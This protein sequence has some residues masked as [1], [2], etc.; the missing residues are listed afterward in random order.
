M[1]KMK[2]FGKLILDSISTFDNLSSTMGEKIFNT[3]ISIKQNNRYSIRDEYLNTSVKKN[4]DMN[5]RLYMTSNKDPDR[6]NLLKTVTN[7]CSI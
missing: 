2:L 5:S 4:N 7:K 1:S 3:E 6:L